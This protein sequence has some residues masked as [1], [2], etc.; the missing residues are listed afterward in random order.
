MDRFHKGTKKCSDC[1]RLLEVKDLFK[2]KWDKL[3]CKECLKKEKNM[4]SRQNN[5]LY[6]NYILQK[7][8]CDLNE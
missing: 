2:G 1:R 6:I 5:T 4:S 7:M 8:G 3:F